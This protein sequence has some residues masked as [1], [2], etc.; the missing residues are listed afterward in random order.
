MS[1][2]R[3]PRIVALIVLAAGPAGA[4]GPPVVEVPAEST[5]LVIPIRVHLLSAADLPEV[6]CHLGEADI[7]RIIGKV[8]EIWGVAGISFGLESI[9]REPAANVDRYKAARDADPGGWA[10]LGACRLLAP[11]DSLEFDGL[12]VYYL[13][14]F[15]VNGVYLGRDIAFVQETAR[16]RPVEGGLDEPIPRVTAHELGHALS[17][18]HRQAVTNL[19]ASGN[20]GYTLNPEEVD[21]SRRRAA[22]TPGALA[23]PEL[24]RRAEAAE[25]AGD[26]Q[27]AAQLWGWLA[28]VPGPSALPSRLRGL[29]AGP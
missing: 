28:E 27:L 2:R 19:L 14:R 16:L 23:W 3:L 12:H 29:A 15:S 6:D 9:R 11:A 1:T 7:R 13:H 21:R 18:P 5:F 24:R 4:Q 20:D 25:A 10:P 8:N 17:L 26:R 22:T